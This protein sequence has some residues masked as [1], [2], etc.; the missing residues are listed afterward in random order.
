M[1]IVYYVDTAPGTF[2]A[3]A[4]NDEPANSPLQPPLVVVT[5]SQ[6]QAE[7]VGI[8]QD[9]SIDLNELYL[10]VSR[11]KDRENPQRLDNSTLD[12][13]KTYAVFLYDPLLQGLADLGYTQVDFDLDTVFQN[14]EV[15]A[16]WDYA[17]TDGFGFANKVIFTPGSHTI[18]AHITYGGGTFTI[19]ATFDVD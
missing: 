10:Q 18:D 8:W 9:P 19:S 1:A 15:S 14:S 13:G 16:P 7:L 17:G 5:Q 11:S 12:T 4:E 2:V 6:Y 3:A